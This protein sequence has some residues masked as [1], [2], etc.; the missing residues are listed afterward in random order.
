MNFTWQDWK[1]AQKM[2]ELYNKHRVLYYSY[3]LWL[4]LQSVI[5]F[6]IL[7]IIV[8]FLIFVS[9]WEEELFIALITIIC[10]ISW[11]WGYFSCILN[12]PCKKLFLVDKRKYRKI[13]DSINEISRK[14]KGPKIHEIYII[15]EFNAAAT[16]RY[17]FTPFKRNILILGYPLLCALSYRG[18]VGCLAHEIGHI[19]HRHMS[20]SAW[21]I[22]ANAFWSNIQLGILTFIFIPWLRY[23]LPAFNKAIAPLYRQQE[24]EADKFIVKTFGED[25]L[26]ACMI[27][28]LLKEEQYSDVIE[29]LL[30][31]MRSVDWPQCD[32]LKFYRDGLYE[33]LPEERDERVLEHEL[34]AVPNVFDEHPSFAQRLELANCNHP[35]RF[36]KFNAD[37][38]ERIGAKDANLESELNESFHSTF[39]EYSQAIHEAAKEARQW[40]FEN[41]PSVDTMD[42]NTLCLASSY[43][44]NA[45]L[46]KEKLKLLEQCVNVFPDFIQFRAMLALEHTKDDPDGAAAELEYCIEQSPILYQLDDNDFLLN[47]YIDSGD[48]EKIHSYLDLKNG[49][50]QQINAQLDKE[51]GPNDNLESSELPQ[52][53]KDYLICI[54]NSKYTFVKRAYCV[55][56]AID[57][58]TAI[59]QNLIVLD[60]YVEPFTLTLYKVDDVLRE[61]SD[62]LMNTPYFVIVGN[63]KL[64]DNNLDLIKGA[65]F[66]S[67][68]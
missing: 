67:K 17:I 19:K 10:I 61:L 58:K 59:A 39:S 53:I 57:D 29:A 31:Q 50:I 65:K 16:N 42:E 8:S 28:M 23:W 54:F 68:N 26:A 66:Y 41:P 15:P 56:R 62:V 5:A 20:A 12:D 33:D 13:Y 63:K 4:T 60:A 48:E 55:R 46:K 30:N 7:V 36:A 21:I 49:R 32:I 64:C 45:G 14:I 51:L 1:S 34:K 38:L 52:D 43:L 40:L 22:M 25:Y 47:Y 3:L 11:A 18:L 2:I 44:E 35:I 24:I 6:A 27:E 37:A 9:I